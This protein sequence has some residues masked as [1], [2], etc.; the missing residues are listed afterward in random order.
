MTVKTIKIIFR[1]DISC[2]RKVSFAIFEDKFIERN[3]E[4]EVFRSNY[5]GW[6]TEKRRVVSWIKV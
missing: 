4:G 5:C 2:S 3:V 1:V 6:D